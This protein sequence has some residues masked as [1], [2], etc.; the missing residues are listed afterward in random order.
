MPG[1]KIIFRKGLLQITEVP[2]FVA[3][4]QKA[5]DQLISDITIWMKDKY[6][7]KILEF[8]ESNKLTGHSIGTG[9]IHMKYLKE[10]LSSKI[11]K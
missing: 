8:I 3:E 2:H 1:L 11:S 10:Y 6:P 5:F 9:L 4:D 7:D